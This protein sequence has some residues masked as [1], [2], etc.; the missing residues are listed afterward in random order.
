MQ[1]IL[2][3]LTLNTARLKTSS[4]TNEALKHCAAAHELCPTMKET[5]LLTNQ[6]V[7]S[8]A[9]CHMWYLG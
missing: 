9:Q 4:D 7:H 1:I 3:L 6:K 5:S 8:I 2:H